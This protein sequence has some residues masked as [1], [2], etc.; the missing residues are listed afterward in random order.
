MMEPPAPEARIVPEE[1]TDLVRVNTSHDLLSDDEIR[2]MFRL[3]EALYASGLYD[4]VK[5]AEAAFAK[6]VIGRDLGLSP[7][8]SMQGLHLVEGGVSAHYAML[9]QFVRARDGYDFRPG[10][11]KEEPR[12]VVDGMDPD[13][14]ATIVNVWMDEE[15]PDDLRP[16]VGA[17]IEFT[18][19]DKRRG[20]SRFTVEDA[21]TANLIK[22]SPKAAW[23]TARRNMLLA[24][25]MS[26]GVKWFVPE[27]LGGMPMYVEGELTQRQELT[28]GTGDGSAQGIDLGPKVDAVIARAQELGHTGLSDRA[29]LELALGRRSPAVVEKFVKDSTKE[30]DAFEQSQGEAAEHEQ[31]VDDA[32]ATLAV[33]AEQTA[34]E[35]GEQIDGEPGSEPDEDVPL[36]EKE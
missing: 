14:P 18:V 36:S 32:N 9:G 22:E 26:N 34:D 31:V 15:E 35:L 29:T 27:V 28:S 16:V 7:M 17:V 6:M 4:D 10:W 23:N 8:Q 12:I 1:S 30:L 25:A 5:K 3:A 33:D 21:K 13:A 11:L 24:R 2:R 19:G 20:V